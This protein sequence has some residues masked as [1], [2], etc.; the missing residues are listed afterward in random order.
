MACR[1][2]EETLKQADFFI[3]TPAVSKQEDLL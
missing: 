1:R 2:I 3:A